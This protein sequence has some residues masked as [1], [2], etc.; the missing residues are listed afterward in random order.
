[1]GLERVDLVVDLAAPAQA[2]LDRR[3][4]LGR[5]LLAGAAGVVVGAGADFAR[6]GV[7]LVADLLRV[8]L[9]LGA[10]LGAVGLGLATELLGL[11]LG[12]QQAR[13]APVRRPA[14][15]RGRRAAR[16]RCRPRGRQL[17]QP[18]G[19]AVRRAERP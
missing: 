1:M 7:G 2:L 13:G 19:A 5:R 10:H 12:G 6:V 8:G 14:A 16:A 9:G 4:G 17:A 3:G 18:T 11:L 15:A